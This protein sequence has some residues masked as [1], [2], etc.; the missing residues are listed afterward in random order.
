MEMGE[1][2]GR[3]REGGK[4]MGEVGG[5]RDEELMMGEGKVK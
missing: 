2:G 3:E 5:R 4:V 1:A